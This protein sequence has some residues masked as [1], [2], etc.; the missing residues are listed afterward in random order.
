VDGVV[1]SLTT[2]RTEGELAGRQGISRWAVKQMDERNPV[3]YHPLLTKMVEFLMDN[4]WESVAV[5]A[6][7][8]KG[9]EPVFHFGGDF[10]SCLGLF[11]HTA[12]E[13]NSSL[14]R[15]LDEY[16]AAGENEEEEDD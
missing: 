7:H 1:G 15:E 5:V 2:A 6:Q 13:L 10:Y 3:S 4:G 9:D 8:G 12:F 16:W 11:Q 14:D